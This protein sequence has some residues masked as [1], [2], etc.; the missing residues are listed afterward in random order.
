VRPGVAPSGILPRQRLGC[1]SLPLPASAT[2]G[3]H[4]LGTPLGHSC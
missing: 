1:P 3:N 4:A 2:A